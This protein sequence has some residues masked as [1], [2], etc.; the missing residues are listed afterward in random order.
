V[1][2]GDVVEVIRPTSGAGTGKLRAK[3]GHGY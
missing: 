3:V 2:P 1:V